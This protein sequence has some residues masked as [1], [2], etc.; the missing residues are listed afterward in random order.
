[1]IGKNVIRQNTSIIF[2]LLSFCVFLTSTTAVAAT[3]TLSWDHN[4]TPPDGYRI[5]SRKTN[6]AYNYSR[7][8]WEGNVVTTTLIGL[9]ENTEYF[10]VVRAYAGSLESANSN[11]V[12]FIPNGFSA[13]AGSS[14]DP[15]GTVTGTNTGPDTDSSAGSDTGTSSGTSTAPGS[16]SLEPKFAGSSLTE[17][18]EYYTDRSYQLTGVPSQY[19]GMESII[20]PNNDRNRTDASGYLKFTMPDDGVV[21]VAYDSRATRRPNWLNGF[22]D[23]GDVIQ[24]SLSTQPYLKILSREYQKD[25]IVDLGANKAPGFSGRTVS[26]YVVFYGNA[27][28]G[29]TTSTNTG[30]S[31]DDGSADCPLASK[32]ETSTIGVSAYFYADRNYK[33]TGGI[34]D[35]MLGREII[36][37]PNNDLANSANSGYLRFSNPIKSWVYV[38]FDSRASSVPNWLNGWELLSDIRIKTSLGSQPYLKVYRKMFSAGQ[39]VDLGG[40]YGP[41]S[42]GEYR[43]NYIVVY[44]K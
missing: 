21:Y 40:N 9:E 16:V 11:E 23:T 17:G 38:L 37:T 4:D 18:V 12:H 14:V 19:D 26:N 24:T 3:V 22:F 36:Q 15:T 2:I 31:M 5:F 27:S 30:T 29:T 39:C 28:G 13:D 34:P 10:F 32:F 35:W 41:G 42:S 7:P 33:I 1:M 25:A 44:G 43:S 6:Q 20:L 8:I